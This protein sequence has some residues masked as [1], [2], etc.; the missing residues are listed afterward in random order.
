M[1]EM[2]AVMKEFAARAREERFELQR[3]ADCGAVAWPPRD[4]CGACWSDCLEWMPVSPSGVVLAATALHAPLEEFFRARTP[5][6]IG[7]VRLEAGPVAYAHLHGAV[8]EGDEIQIEARLD[9]QG[10]GVLIAMPK[11]GAR[12]EDDRN[13][14]ELISAKGGF[15]ERA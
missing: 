14:L 8:A 9:H 11:S 7:T 3:C 12:I 4:V 1:I 2:S 10:R 13:L 6:R 15:N 5:W